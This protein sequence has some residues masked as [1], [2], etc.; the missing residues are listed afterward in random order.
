MVAD[1]STAFCGNKFEAIVYTNGLMIGADGDG[2]NSVR[3]FYARSTTATT[4][5]LP[6]TTM[7][8]TNISGFVSGAHPE[9]SATDRA[10]VTV[11]DKVFPVTSNLETDVS[12]AYVIYDFLGVEEGLKSIHNGT[13]ACAG[14]KISVDGQTVRCR[15]R[16]NSNY[17]AVRVA[18]TKFDSSDDYIKIMT[19][20]TTSFCGGDNNFFGLG[21]LLDSCDTYFTCYTGY[22]TPGEIVT[23]EFSSNTMIKSRCRPGVMALIDV[24]DRAIL[25]P[26]NCTGDTPLECPLART[27]LSISQIC[28]RTT[29]CP[30]N[31]DEA[32]CP[33]WKAVGTQLLPSCAPMAFDSTSTT[34]TACKRFAILQSTP[35]VLTYNSS[36]C[37]VYDCVDFT[38]PQLRALPAATGDGTTTNLMVYTR[39]PFSFLY[40]TADLQCNGNGVVSS[41]EAPCACTCDFNY[42]GKDCAS[43]R[44][45]DY[46]SGLVFVY[47]AYTTINAGVTSPLINAL[48]LHL[49]TS[50]TVAVRFVEKTTS[51]TFVYLLTKDPSG[52]ATSSYELNT[53]FYNSTYTNIMKYVSANGGGIYFTTENSNAQERE[54]Q[55]RI[56]SLNVSDATDRTCSTLFTSVVNDPH[57]L[58][59]EIQGVQFSTDDQYVDVTLLDAQ[60]NS[61]TVQRCSHNNSVNTRDSTITGSCG[62]QTSCAFHFNSSETANSLI[63]NV[64][65][66]STRLSS[67]MNP[68]SVVCNGYLGNV[69]TK[70]SGRSSM[71]EDVGDTSVPSSATEREAIYLYL[72]FGILAI[73]VVTTILFVTWFR[74]RTKHPKM[75]CIGPLLAGISLFLIG[76]GFCALGFY[77][78]TETANYSHMIIVE[79]YR[80]EMCT[81]SPISSLPLSTSIAPANGKCNRVLTSGRIEGSLFVSASY[82]ANKAGIVSFRAGASLRDCEADTHNAL[83]LQSCDEERAYMPWKPQKDGNYVSLRASTIGKAH[84]RLEQ[85]RTNN[86]HPGPTVPV[87]VTVLPATQKYSSAL[88]DSLKFVYDR[89]KSQTI[90]V[91]N[92]SG[93]YMVPSFNDSFNTFSAIS[94]VRFQETI[95]VERTLFT[96]GGGVAVDSLPANAVISNDSTYYPAGALFNS[97]D[98]DYVINGRFSA[99]SSSTSSSSRRV[100]SAVSSASIFAYYFLDIPATTLQMAESKEFTLTFWT[101]MTRADRGFVFAT[102]DSWLTDSGTSPILTELANLIESGGVA[103]GEIFLQGSLSEWTVYSAIYISG[104]SQEVYLL[105]ATSNKAVEY[106][107]WSV[108]DVGASRLFN[109]G[110]HFLTVTSLIRGSSREYQLYVDGQSD[111]TMNGWVKCNDFEFPAPNVRSTGDTVHVMNDREESVLPGEALVVGQLDG[112]VF[113]IRLYT[114]RVYTQEEIFLLGADGMDNYYSIAVA[115]SLVIGIVTAILTA[116]MVLYS[117]YRAFRREFGVNEDEF[118]DEAVYDERGRRIYTDKKAQSRSTAFTSSVRF[119]SFIEPFLLL[120]QVI[121]LFIT[122]WTWPNDYSDYFAPVAFVSFDLNYFLPGIPLITWVLITYIIAMVL[123]GLFV[124]VVAKQAKGFETVVDRYRDM[125]RVRGEKKNR[126]KKLDDE[127]FMLD[128]PKPNYKWFVNAKGGTRQLTDDQEELLVEN[129]KEICT[130]RTKRETNMRVF[131]KKLVDMGEELGEG[132]ILY[133]RLQG[134]I[135]ISFRIS[136]H[137]LQHD[138]QSTKIDVTQTYFELRC[139]NVSCPDHKHRLLPEDIHNVQ[140]VHSSN[141]YYRSKECPTKCV[142]YICPEEGCEYAVCEHCYG[143]GALGG[144][145]ADA[146]QKIKSAKKKGITHAMGSML[147]LL[148]GLIYMPSV[149][150]ALMII[151]CHNTYRCEFDGCWES[152]SITY[153]GMVLFSVLILVCIGVG[154]IYLQIHVLVS[155]RSIMAEVLPL[156]T[157]KHGGGHNTVVAKFLAKRTVL[158]E[159]YIDFLELD[160]TIAGAI[161]RP[162]E[163]DFFATSPLLLFYRFLLTIVVV[164]ISPNTLFQLGGAT[165]VSLIFC[166]MLIIISPYV[167]VWLELLVRLGA[168]HNLTQLALF[169]L[170][171]VDIRDDPNGGGYTSQM[172]AVTFLYLSLIHISEPTRLLSISYAVFCLKKKKKKKKKNILIYRTYQTKKIN[173]TI[174]RN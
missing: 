142:M 67:G 68:L 109:G 139:D 93:W 94:E 147:M 64:A 159:D 84:E 155:R 28:D 33:L 65:R 73:G 166:F 118:E 5:S 26:L 2:S 107:R 114:D 77:L 30:D 71:V 56:S 171:R 18:Q 162:Y 41:T 97:F 88:P 101:K 134:R 76:F 122:M 7:L 3:T 141:P 90:R 174:K 49:Q 120:L 59:V 126:K 52:V 119:S 158:R 129:L 136:M 34:E 13:I 1:S 152:P 148:T 125:I 173:N 145:V 39:D 35:T 91:P 12:A 100:E 140:C 115:E 51:Y 169:S 60:N 165:L 47:P 74:L 131:T 53:L 135:F 144:G 103:G 112:G 11:F 83:F 137:D 55:C 43:A 154:F 149:K 128:L 20:Q 4:T 111:P 116:V 19:S 50:S 123:F 110:W 168:F 80:D 15:F 150:Y 40:C 87:E 38:N 143:G 32:R 66:I 138:Q 157:R 164:L 72:F 153:L 36:G 161:Y 113:G 133:E 69:V 156:Q 117:L 62:Y 78:A 82:G 16:V 9:M 167:N 27:C 95:E 24:E 70:I 99:S 54:V 96:T 163:Y 108:E 75:F 160:N 42:L 63:A 170:H 25:P 44:R 89:E 146:M 151:S 58:T 46:S 106:I 79:D 57:T 81:N 29:D 48:L 37:A 86:P 102:T 105:T 61:L 127:L 121:T 23:I 85:T 21:G 8:K 45:T 14:D 6:T 98:V 10:K 22:I 124:A 92:P 130:A 104:Y 17:L 132:I 172:V 31:S